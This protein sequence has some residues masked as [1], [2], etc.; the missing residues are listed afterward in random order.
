MNIKNNLNIKDNISIPILIINS[1]NNIYCSYFCNLAQ[2]K[3]NQFLFYN[4]IKQENLYNQLDANYGGVYCPKSRCIV[5]TREYASNRTLIH[6]LGHAK[7]DYELDATTQNFD[8]SFLEVH[9]MI[10]NENKFS[11]E[12]PNNSLL[13]CYLIISDNDII[14]GDNIDPLSQYKYYRVKYN[15]EMNLF[16]YIYET[17][18]PKE[19]DLI[20]DNHNTSLM[21]L[22][23]KNVV[24]NIENYEGVL[25]DERGKISEGYG[26]RTALSSLMNFG[27]RSLLNSLK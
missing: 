17:F 10:V 7:Q 8:R 1:E 23:M 6:E 16:E 27:V 5:L 9:N 13:E 24:E 20:H 14:S 4:K 12:K 11:E 2:F 21:Y 26:L 22:Q 18:T 3:L 15:K 25:V 19:M